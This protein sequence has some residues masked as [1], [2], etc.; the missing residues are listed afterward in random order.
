MSGRLPEP[1]PRLRRLIESKRVRE[2][3]FTRS[4]VVNLSRKAVESARDAQLPG[5]SLDGALRSAYDAA[6][7]GCHALLATR[8]LRPAGGQGHHEVTFAAV[9]ALGFEGLAELVP[10]SERVRALRKGSV[11]DP[12]L[13]T[14]ADRQVAV[15][16]MRSVLPRMRTALIAWDASLEREVFSVPLTP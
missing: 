1:P 13:A 8:H 9:E 6:L 3:E 10:D 15:D 4:D 5:I 16:W 12:V 14:E 2:Q 11:Y 7:N